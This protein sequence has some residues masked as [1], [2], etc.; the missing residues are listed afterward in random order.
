MEI[1]RCEKIR[2][3]YGSGNGQVIA[4][5]KKVNLSQLSGH[6]AL[7]NLR[8]Y[9]SLGVWTNRLREKFL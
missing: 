8:F 4:L 3:V 5:Y 1:L 9:I 6:Q 2:K 7:E